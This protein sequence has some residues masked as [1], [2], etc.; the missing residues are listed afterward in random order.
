MPEIWALA[1]RAKQ[2]QRIRGDLHDVRPF[3]G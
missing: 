1:R 3:V 2:Q